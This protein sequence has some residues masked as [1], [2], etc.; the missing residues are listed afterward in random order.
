MLYEIVTL[1]SSWVVTH[2]YSIYLSELVSIY[3]I[4]YDSIS[5]LLSSSIYIY[6]SIYEGMF[7]FSTFLSSHIYTKAPSMLVFTFSSIE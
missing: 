3:F 6:E 5:T 4:Y 1:L 7:H 2:I